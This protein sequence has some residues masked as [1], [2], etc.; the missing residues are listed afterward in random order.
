M[1][2]N[3]ITNDSALIKSLVSFYGANYVSKTLDNSA[4]IMIITLID[5][6]YKIEYNKS[7][8]ESVYPLLVVKTALSDLL[9]VNEGKVFLHGAALEY[10]GGANVFLAPSFGGKSV[11]SSFLSETGCGFLTDD[12]VIIDAQENMVFPYLVPIHLRD[13]GLTVL[14]QSNVHIHRIETMFVNN[15]LL[16]SY[17]PG[18]CIFKKIPM[19]N[20]FFLV[21][22]SIHNRIIDASHSEKIEF[23]FKSLYKESLIAQMKSN[24]IS[25]AKLRIQWLLYRDLYFVQKVINQ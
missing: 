18:K 17:T 11:L 7:A 13:N 1:P 4:G 24:I 22:N 15:Q 6:F 23:L 2:L 19:S 3:V 25:L 12:C 14:S 8:Y 10:H 9:D 20:C 5:S 21:R 16:H